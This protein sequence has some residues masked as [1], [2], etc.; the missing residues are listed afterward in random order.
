M[1][2]VRTSASLYRETFSPFA[3]TRED[4]AGP[5]WVDPSIGRWHKAFERY[6]SVSMCIA[7]KY[8]TAKLYLTTLWQSFSRH[9]EDFCRAEVPARRCSIILVP[10]FR[11]VTRSWIG[12]HRKRWHWMAVHWC[13]VEND[14]NIISPIHPSSSKIKA[15]GHSALQLRRVQGLGTRLFPT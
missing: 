9:P 13:T 2:H 1:F 15:L 12:H 3:L 5:F 11:L 14:G 7:T 10:L 8:L 6:V 4:Y